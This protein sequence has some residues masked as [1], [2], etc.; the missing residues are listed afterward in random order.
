M[1]LSVA[2]MVGIT[3]RPMRQLCRLL[4]PHAVLYTEMCTDEV[5][6]HARAA[7]V[8]DLLTP[9]ASGHVVLQLAGHEPEKLARAAA[10]G[11]AAGYAEINLNCGCP[12]NKVANRSC[13]G[14]ALMREPDRV[15]EL[16]AAC[17]RC[18]SIPVTVKCRLGVDDCD[19]FEH[20]TRFITSAGEGGCRFFAVHARKALL[21]GLG[22]K[23]NR[24]VP[25]LNY[26]WVA[27][28]ARDFPDYKFEL[29][30]GLTSIDQLQTFRASGVLA[31]CMV[32]REVYRDPCFL[33][34][35]DA[36]LFPSSITSA[37]TRGSVVRAYLDH[38][39]SYVSDHGDWAMARRTVVE[40]LMKLFHA[41]RAA[42]AF[43]LGL[44]SGLQDKNL[45]VRSV[46]EA[47][48]EACPVHVVDE[49]IV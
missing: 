22:T 13:N 34:R 43:R 17:T 26:D 11:E 6:L 45:D 25:A 7:L 30:G 3:T 32:G 44:H 12:S 15:R 41:T 20:L 27:R 42:N 33:A 24:S 14:A 18:V 9:E 38:F 47:A 19:S 37:G 1:R 31:G 39:D 46:V 16:V 28:L 5:L 49:P 4:S 10:M 8:A 36:A 35:A 23:A 21:S 40:P 2:P 29:N 48:L